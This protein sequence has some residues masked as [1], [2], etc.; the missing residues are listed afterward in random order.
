MDTPDSQIRRLTLW[1]RF[2]L[3]LVLLYALS[4]AGNLLTEHFSRDAL[5][6]HLSWSHSATVKDGSALSL[7]KNQGS[8]FVVT[9]LVK[10]AARHQEKAVAAL[11]EPFLIYHLKTSV[12]IT[13]SELAKLAW[14]QLDGKRVAPPR[15]GQPVTAVYYKMLE[16]TTKTTVAN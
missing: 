6:L 7:S 16:V 11:P 4:L 15:P 8:P 2:W 14:I 1:N 9:H 10:E 5:R 3:G 13:P 12:S